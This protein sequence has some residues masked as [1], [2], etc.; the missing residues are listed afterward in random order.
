[1]SQESESVTLPLP[2]TLK[3]IDEA[4]EAFYRQ[5]RCAV[6]TYVR[7]QVTTL[8]DVPILIEEWRKVVSVDR[9]WNALGLSNDPK[10]ELI[11]WAQPT[12]PGQLKLVELLYLEEAEL[13]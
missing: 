8:D 13:L 9:R 12:G 2:T 4:K 1:M 6:Q 10:Q 7:G 3:G 5:Y 11:L